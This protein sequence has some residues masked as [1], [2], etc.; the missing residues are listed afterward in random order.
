M[1]MGGMNNSD[2]LRGHDYTY[3]GSKPGEIAKAMIRMKCKNGVI[4]MDE[5]EKI[6]ENA[7]ILSCLLH[8]TDF[9]QNAHFRDHFFS[10]ITI[11]LSSVWFIYS[12][13]SLPQDSALRDRMFHIEVEGYSI[14]DKMKIV[15]DYLIPK[16]LKNIGKQEDEILFEEKT[17]R[18]FILTYHES[19]KGIR[20]LEKDMKDIVH[21]IYFLAAHNK[22][23]DCSFQLPNS[24]LPIRFPFTIDS[25]VV[26]KLLRDKNPSK[27]YLHMFL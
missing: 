22:R 10:D 27:D 7:D 6:S 11:D 17:L 15:C 19:E 25:V 18:N 3:V 4:F 9:S 23:I 14:E 26:D 24:Y 1:A 20:Q 2:M 8:I 5:F 16:H 12:M 21:K 13:N